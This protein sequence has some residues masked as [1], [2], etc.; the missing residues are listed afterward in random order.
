[1]SE[2]TVNAALRRLGYAQ[3]E[4]T[5]HGFRA[6]AS[7]LLNESRQWHPDAIERQLA[8]VESNDVR[9]AYLRGE[10]W[11]ER[12]RMM[13]WWSDHLDRLKSNGVTK[14]PRRETRSSTSDRAQPAGPRRQGFD[15]R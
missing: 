11:D 10:H 1:M 4:M 6:M 7:T 8:R 13:Q 9:R 12:I 14:Q 15:G 2:N 3:S 5:G